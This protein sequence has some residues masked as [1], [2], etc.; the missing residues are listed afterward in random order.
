MPRGKWTG[1]GCYQKGRQQGLSWT[2][3]TRPV[4]PKR[5]AFPLEFSRSRLASEPKRGE[6]QYGLEASVKCTGDVKTLVI[7]A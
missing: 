3:L 7:Y 6:R 2:N 4:A 1:Q 5:P